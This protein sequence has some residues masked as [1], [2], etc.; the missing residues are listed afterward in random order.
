M[1]TP[2]KF[3][4]GDYVECTTTGEKAWIDDVYPQSNGSRV[5]S[6]ASNDGSPLWMA[7]EHNLRLISA[8]PL[9]VGSINKAVQA[10]YPDVQFGYSCPVEET[11]KREYAP[12]RCECGVDSVGGGIHSP[13]C[14]KA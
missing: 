9:P 12:A 11:Y 8:A 6:L 2:R 13:W 1:N 4:I 7:Q 3:D 5:Y 10:I 14:P